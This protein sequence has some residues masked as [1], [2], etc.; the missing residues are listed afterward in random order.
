MAVEYGAAGLEPKAAK[1]FS[2]VSNFRRRRE[3]LDAI[4]ILLSVMGPWLLFVV[5]FTFASFSVHYSVGW[6]YVSA[7]VVGFLIVT[8]LGVK[9][10]LQFVR[11][12]WER[13]NT[14]EMR[15]PTWFT[16]LFLTT[17]LAWVLA[18]ILGNINFSQNMKAFYN[19][20]NS[21]T[22]TGIDPAITRGAQVADVG[23]IVFTEGTH[24]DLSR[25]M[26]FKHDKTYCVAPISSRS[27]V[28][29][30][31]DFWAVGTDCCSSTQAE[32]QCGAYNDYYAH[33]GL[34]LMD[35]D[36]RPFYRLAVQEAEAQYHILAQ[37]PLFFFWDHDPE[38]SMDTKREAG[39]RF[40][41]IGIASYFCLQLFLVVVASLFYAKVGFL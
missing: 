2:G 31:Y 21:N 40:Y 41:F 9:A 10:M 22:E 27:E 4:S 16:F 30:T 36:A 37:H 18:L 6:L 23:R 20:Q 12:P 26:A 33:G 32:F 24:L 15:E 11:R 28:L 14:T 29:Q 34:R 17:L 19:L 25:A 8:V 13:E 5:L 3:R 38:D 35:D 7:A 1:A 39:L